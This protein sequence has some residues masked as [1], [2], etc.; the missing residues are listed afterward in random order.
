MHLVAR[1]EALVYNVP[2]TNRMANLERSLLVSAFTGL[3]I[4]ACIGI[5]LRLYPLAG[6]MPLQ[7]KNLLHGHSHFAF[8]GWIM[9]ALLLLLLRY[10]PELK[11]NIL[12]RHWRN[13]SAGIIISAY[14]M[15][16]TFPFQGYGPWSVFFSTI[17]IAAGFY[18]A[19]VVWRALRF[20]QRISEKFLKAALVFFV[21]SAI[22]PFATGP[23]VA[24]GKQGSPLYFNSVYFYLHFQ[25]NGWFTFVLLAVLYR[26]F[27]EQRQ[28]GN[29]TVYF[30]FT[31]SALP[32]FF[33]SVLWNSPPLLFN[34]I[35]GSGGLMQLA[36]LILLLKDCKRYN[37]KNDLNLLIKLAL[38]AFSLKTVLQF[39]SALPAVAIL[40]YEYRNFVIAYLHLSLLGF[41]SFFV[42]GS[43]F[44]SFEFP[45]RRNIRWG[46]GLFLL[47]FVLSELLLVM[48]SFFAMLGWRLP[49]YNEQLLLVSIFFPA[50]SLI[51]LR[52]I[53]KSLKGSFQLN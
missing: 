29:R 1:E 30:L 51:I 13:I 4:T 44:R 24:M 28:S 36:G 17:S 41:V 7:Y 33:L 46:A 26:L 52:S 34:I 38:V 37:K 42:V 53:R 23:L 21:I 22:G 32:A 16:C 43:L 6:S 31:A 39:F 47:S 3:V 18:L 19:V 2:A 11:K 20:P 8:G 12:Y 25:I 9:P 10:F 45:L 15:L 50:G 14:G 27:E 40:A 35:G 48:A 5:V 49:F